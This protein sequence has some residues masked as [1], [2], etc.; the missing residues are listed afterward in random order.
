MKMSKLE[1][2]KM[3]AVEKASQVKTMRI[4]IKN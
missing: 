4:R 3:M 1:W 2:K